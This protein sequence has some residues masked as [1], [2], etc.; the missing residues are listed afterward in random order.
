VR[1]ERACPQRLNC[2][3][4]RCPWPSPGVPGAT[5]HSAHSAGYRAEHRP[6]AS[7]PP[8]E[9]A[10]WRARVHIFS[11]R[12]GWCGQPRRARMSSPPSACPRGCPRG[13][14]QAR[15]ASTGSTLRAPARGCPQP[16]HHPQRT[17]RAG[18]GRLAWRQDHAAW[19]AGETSHRGP[20]P[21][22]KARLPA[23]ERNARMCRRLRPPMF[24][25]AGSANARLAGYSDALH[26]LR[27]LPGT[28]ST[29]APESR[30]V[31]GTRSCSS[32]RRGG[33]RPGGSLEVGNHEGG[34]RRGPPRARRALEHLAHAVEIA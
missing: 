29:K 13:C 12:C 30:P 23:A 34:A 1:T 32:S 26:R 33:S 11:R 27:H 8:W 19:P 17:L 10:G 14:G 6:S 24:R 3:A 9:G 28:P 5:I 16:R 18:R 2:R 4:G 15:A 20:I 25:A 7:Q 31:G 21:A 22:R